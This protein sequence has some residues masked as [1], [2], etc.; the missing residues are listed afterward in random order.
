MNICPIDGTQLEESKLNPG[1][2][3]CKCCKSN[4]RSGIFDK[5][6]LKPKTT[7]SK[8][9]LISDIMDNFEFNKVVSVMKF[10]DWQWAGI[11]KSPFNRG[12]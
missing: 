8:N 5:L 6:D 12:D 9:K 1:A 3:L 7:D 2:Y 11:R 4:S 10:L